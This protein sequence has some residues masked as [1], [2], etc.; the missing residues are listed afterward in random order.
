MVFLKEVGGLRMAEHQ[1]R[2]EK[3]LD[4]SDTALL[5]EVGGKLAF[6]CTAQ[7]LRSNLWEGW[8]C[9]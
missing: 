7:Q 9:E 6:H 1:L 8:R 5:M 2:V 3:A 4:K